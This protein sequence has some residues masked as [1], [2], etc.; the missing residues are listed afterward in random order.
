MPFTVSHA[1]AVLP[2]A[3]G[4]PARR[5]VPAALV[6]GSMVPDLPYFV[7]FLSGADQTH[8]VPGPV[9][10]DLAY[11]LV[12]WLLWDLVLVRALADLAPTPLQRRLPTRP[13]GSVPRVV[14]AAVSVVLGAITHVVW[15][16]FSHGGRYASSRID[17]LSAEHLGLLGFTWVQYGSGVLGLLGLAAWVLCWFTSTRP[18][19]VERRTSSRHRR[20]SWAAVAVAFAGTVLAVWISTAVQSGR[21]FDE[22]L[23]FAVA[24]RAMGATAGAIVLVCLVWTALVRPGR[25]S[26]QL[27]L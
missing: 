19:T 15:D 16:S 21:L 25:R 20:W 10:T 7:P 24:T 12:L 3:T 8:S 26:E 2:L 27:A 14:W 1:L 22:R 5:L 4:R 6:I 18:R 17:W 13:A 23:A 9:T 11:G